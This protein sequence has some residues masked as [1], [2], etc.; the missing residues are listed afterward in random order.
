MDVVVDRFVVSRRHEKAIRAGIAST[1]LVGDSLM[2][3]HVAG[4]A[5]RKSADRF[6]RALCSPTWHFV[7]GDIGP[8]V[9]RVQQARERVPHVRRAWRRQADTS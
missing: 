3:V 9:L 4:G 8:G 6:Y 2:Q 5:D 1:L 7:Y